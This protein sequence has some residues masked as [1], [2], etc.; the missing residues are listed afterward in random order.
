MAR[1]DLGF[2]NRFLDDLADA[3]IARVMD[4]VNVNGAR[5]GTLG[6]RGPSKLR[7]RKLDM[8]CRYPGCPNKSKGPR[9]SFLCGKH[10]KMPR[11]E[12]MAAIEKAQAKAGG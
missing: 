5:K 8:R 10:L 9:F 1:N 3:F 7:G 2:L 12:V 6:R 11:R 4:R